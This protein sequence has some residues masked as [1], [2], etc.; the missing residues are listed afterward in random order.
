MQ[1]LEEGIFYENCYPGV[2]VGAL[3]LSHGLLLI[4]A[5]LRTEDIRNWR[6]VLHSRGNNTRLLVSL[7]AHLDRLLGVRMMEAPVLV[8]HKT[9]STIKK[10]PSVFKGQS[11][12]SGSEWELCAPL[13]SRRWTSQDFVFTSEVTLH[14]G[15]HTVQVL[16]MPGPMSGACWTVIPDAKIAFIGDAIVQHQPPFLGHAH[17]PTWLQTLDVLGAPEYKDFTLVSGRGGPVS[18]QDI[19]Q[20]YELLAYIH[21]KMES[22]AA[23]NASIK[24][25]R[26][27]APELLERIEY[28]PNRRGFYTMRLEYGLERYYRKHYL[29]EEKRKK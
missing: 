24:T 17:I 6:S 28:P 8:H 11:E 29:P 27:L 10:Y 20:Q 12:E 22:M 4:D 3:S 18:A 19:Q 5:P 23:E 13:G 9:G 7:D 26:A 14:W 1:I 2:T 15:G 25:V 16:H 21:Q